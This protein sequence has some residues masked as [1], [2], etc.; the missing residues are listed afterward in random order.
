MRFH[1]SGTLP[2]DL[3]SLTGTSR[4]EDLKEALE[5]IAALLVMVAV[6]LLV[7]IAAVPPEPRDIPTGWEE[8]RG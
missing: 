4:H 1:R 6:F 3:K 8:V 2:P 5:T 7:M